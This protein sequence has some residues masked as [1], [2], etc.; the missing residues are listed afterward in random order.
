MKSIQIV[1]LVFISSIFTQAL[2]QVSEEDAFYIKA[3]HD[4]V[5]ERGE[6]YDWLTHLSENIGARL[7]GSDNYNRAADYTQQ[8]LQN[9]L[10]E[11][12]WR[13]SSE[14]D[15]WERGTHASV[16]I[17][18]SYGKQHKLR[19]LALGRSVGT[20]QSGISA[21]VIEVKSLDEVENLGRNEIEDKI[22]FFNRPMNPTQ[23][24]TFNAYGGA[25][26]QRVWGASK[27]AE[28]G[29]VGV[30]VRSMTLR[31]DD[32][33]H[34]GSMAYKDGIPKVPAIAISTND[35]NLLSENLNSGGIVTAT[36]NADCGPKG[37]RNSDNVIAEI[38]G[39][40]FPDEIILVGGHLDSW[41]VGGGAHDDGSG[42]VHAMEVLRT[43]KKLGYVPKRTIRC[44]LFANEENGLAGATE[45]ARISNEN[46]EY[47]L[48]AIESDAGGFVPRGFS[49]DG[50]SEIFSNFAKQV[51]DWLPLLEPYGLTLWT[52]GSGADISPLKSQKGLLIGLRPD[53]QRYFD[54][55]HTAIDRIDAVNERELKL[56]AA[57][58]ASLVFLIDK[59]GLKK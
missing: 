27:A 22:V 2:T 10:I 38:R 31:Q 48:A 33:P 11:K 9:L 53:S 56:G 32:V 55:H 24:R 16:V 5:L 25:V 8:E 52:G 13:Q 59:Y 43:L 54:Y 58:M 7:S 1:F 29:A 50:D 51:N 17:T 34:T 15:Y 18:D 30:L 20:P 37:K 45:Y 42:C 26:D 14:V 28:Y 41:D 39:S 57:A 12:I 49:M 4:E 40:E 47:H 35:A 44:V 3:I 19:C 36:M 46:S 23:L 21:E 6:C